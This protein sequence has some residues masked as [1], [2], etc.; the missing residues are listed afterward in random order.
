MKKY[1]LKLLLVFVIVNIAANA[2]AQFFVKIRPYAPIIV[3]PI[4]PSPRHAWVEGEWAWRD[5]GYHYVNGYW[6]T[7][8]RIG[9]VWI[10]GH[11]KSTRLGWMWKPGH[12][13]RR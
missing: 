11:W 12:W 5:R 6:A 2:D 9:S 13:S 3:R 10:P 7:P 4:A 1:F 8:L